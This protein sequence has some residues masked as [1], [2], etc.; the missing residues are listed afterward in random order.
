MNELMTTDGIRTIYKSITPKSQY[1]YCIDPGVVDLK[2]DNKDLV[3][4][5]A[6]TNGYFYS[7]DNTSVIAS[8]SGNIEMIPNES[9]VANSAEIV[10]GLSS[11][12][13]K[14]DIVDT[15]VDSILLDTDEL[16][17]N[18]GDWLTAT[19]FSTFDPATDT[20]ANV[21]L[22]DTT[23]T[24]TDMRGTDGANTVA[25]DN[26]GIT[27]N[28]S[29]I[30]SLNDI[31]LSEIEGSTVLAKEA[32]LSG[33]ASQSSIDALNDFDPSSDTVANVTTVQMTVS[34]TDMR[35]TDSV[36]TNPLLDTD[37]RLN[38]LDATISSR[39]TFD[40]STDE[41]ITDSASREA[42]KADVSLLGTHADLEVILEATK[43]SA[44]LRKY[45]GD[46]P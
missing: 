7:L 28:G 24:N 37:A 9:Y 36:P 17:Q 12:E 20:I 26:A 41:V 14:V 1:R 23:T 34:N 45:N 2:L 30:S 5:L 8:G 22:V 33:K 6:I 19:G 16:Q 35:G 11:I 15:N 10:S 21:T 3:N 39:S 40:K 43:L 27:A 32:T 4:S 29:A 44:S 13:S 46:L 38:N 31:S 25:P 42:S 18:Q